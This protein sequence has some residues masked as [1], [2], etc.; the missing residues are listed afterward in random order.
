MLNNMAE[1]G[2]YQLGNL[3][4]LF[5][6]GKQILHFVRLMRNIALNL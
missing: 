4:N 1:P 6:N 5:L 2:F 3:F